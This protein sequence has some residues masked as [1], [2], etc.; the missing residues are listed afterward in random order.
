MHR[1]LK[2]QLKKTGYIEDNYSKEQFAKFIQMV[3]QTYC[4]SDEDRLL[5][6][7]TLTISSKEMQE[8]YKKLEISL[9]SELA[10]SEDKYS[11]LV[12]NLKNYYFFTP[13]IKMEFLP[14]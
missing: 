12:Q 13:T 3:E 9:Q 5:L 14:I 7:N 4:E 6:E 10:Q 8:L 11:R 1:L 2:R